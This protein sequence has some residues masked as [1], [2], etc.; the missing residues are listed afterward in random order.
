MIYKNAAVQIVRFEIGKD[1]LKKVAYQRPIKLVEQKFSNLLDRYSLVYKISSKP[2]DYIFVAAR[3]VTADVPNENKDCF[4][5]YELLRLNNEGEFVYETFN[6]DPLLTEHDDSDITT[7]SGMII[8]A[9]YDDS[10][11]NDKKVINLLAIDT[12][13]NSRLATK[14]LS[15][16]VQG[17][18]MGCVCDQTRCSACNN[19]A[20]N[21]MEFCS[22]VKNKY[23]LNKVYGKQ[24]FEWC[25]G[26]TFRELSYVGE[27]ADP[28]ALSLEVCAKKMGECFI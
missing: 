7:A 26:V 10:A 15:K 4:G 12:K 5:E 3:A 18:S 24:V 1:A 6:S 27:P 11:E 28:S 25:E 13:K 21:P 17:F 14:L 23:L 19:V 8:D 22:H 9:Y 16:K 20:V 2:E